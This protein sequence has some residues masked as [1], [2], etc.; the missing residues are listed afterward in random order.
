[1]C[2][3]GLAPLV[4]VFTGLWVWLRKRRAERFELRRRERLAA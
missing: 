3:A 1:M 4:L 2:V